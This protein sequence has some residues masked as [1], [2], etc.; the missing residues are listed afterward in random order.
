MSQKEEQLINDEQI[1]SEENCFCD[2]KQCMLG[3]TSIAIGIGG[4]ALAMLL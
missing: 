2:K 4:F 1:Q 3:I